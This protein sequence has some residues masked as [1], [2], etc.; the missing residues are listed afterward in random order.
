[1]RPQ[2]RQIVEAMPADDFDLVA[3]I[4]ADL[5]HI[6]HLLSRVRDKKA[7]MVDA[8]KRLSDGDREIMQKL[9]DRELELIRSDARNTRWRQQEGG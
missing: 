6:H 2:A 9:L 3:S 4:E 7:K 5:A 8:L 1:M